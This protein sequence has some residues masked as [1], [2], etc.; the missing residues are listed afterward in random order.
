MRLGRFEG[1]TLESRGNNSNSALIAKM[2]ELRAAVFGR[3]FDLTVWFADE[4]IE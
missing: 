3:R 4:V 2:H 1:H